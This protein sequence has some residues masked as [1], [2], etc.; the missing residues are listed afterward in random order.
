MK[1]C[2]LAAAAMF[3]AAAGCIAAQGIGAAGAIAGTVVDPTGAVISGASVELQNT[4]THF[5][6]TVKTDNQGAFRF[7]NL[8]TFPYHLTISAPGFQ[9]HTMDVNVTGTVP[10]TVPI[11][12][13]LASAT[14]TLNVT[15]SAAEV[16][17]VPTAHTDLGPS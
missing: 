2:L 9:P 10:V 16:E 1:N 3:G 7:P 6:R 15:E 11:T 13:Q 8:A 5:D 14:T 17:S 4:N 12:L